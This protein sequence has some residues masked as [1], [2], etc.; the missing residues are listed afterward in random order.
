MSVKKKG[1]GSRGSTVEGSQSRGK[2][3]R[4]GQISGKKFSEIF[5]GDELVLG[6]EGSV[7]YEPSLDKT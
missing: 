4:G 5:G 7:E 6:Q 2:A 1:I 3:G